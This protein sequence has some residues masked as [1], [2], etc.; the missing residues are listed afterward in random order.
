MCVQPVAIENVS[1]DD[2]HKEEILWQRGQMTKNF[3]KKAGIE[4]RS[5]DP[6]TRAAGNTGVSANDVFQFYVCAI[7]SKV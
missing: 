4:L 5:E 3:S 6:S 1:G 7:P 2:R